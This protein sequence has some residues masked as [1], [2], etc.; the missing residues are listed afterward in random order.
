MDSEFGKRM[1]DFLDHLSKADKLTAICATFSMIDWDT[2]ST[3]YWK[4]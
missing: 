4:D 3:R 1:G 2:F